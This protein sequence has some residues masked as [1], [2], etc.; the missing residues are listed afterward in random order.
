MRLANGHPTI[1]QAV[2]AS[3]ERGRAANGLATSVRVCQFGFRRESSIPGGHDGGDG[4]SVIRGVVAD[5]DRNRPFSREDFRHAG[6]NALGAEVAKMTWSRKPR[7]MTEF[8]WV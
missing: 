5:D 2:D 6:A 3:T 1:D 4:G 7:S 8:P